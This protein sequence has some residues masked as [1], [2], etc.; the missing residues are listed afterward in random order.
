MES[1][2]WKRDFLIKWKTMRPFG[3]SLIKHNKR[4]ATA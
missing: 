4:R 3:Y 2:S 1:L